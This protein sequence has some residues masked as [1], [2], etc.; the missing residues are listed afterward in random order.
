MTILLSACVATAVGCEYGED[1]RISVETETTT[2]WP[3]R[4]CMHAG[5]RKGSTQL[6]TEL[7]TSDMKA[8][9]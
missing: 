1:N 9:D 5:I 2:K 8:T 4:S 6:R 3:T 7:S